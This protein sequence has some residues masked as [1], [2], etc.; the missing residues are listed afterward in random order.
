MQL[1]MIVSFIIG[2]GEQNFVLAASAAIV[3]NMYIGIRLSLSSL[4]TQNYNI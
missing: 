2:M 3:A 4:L 1:G